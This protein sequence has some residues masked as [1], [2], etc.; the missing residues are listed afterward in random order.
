MLLIKS[1]LLWA[2]RILAHRTAWRATAG[3]NSFPP[4][5]SGAPWAKRG[6]QMGRLIPLLLLSLLLTACADGPFDFSRDGV[7]DPNDSDDG[8]FSDDDDDGVPGGPGAGPMGFFQIGYWDEVPDAG[9]S[10]GG[11]GAGFNAGFIDD[12]TQG[13][14]STGGVNFNRAK[15]PDSCG[16]T[17]W[18]AEDEETEG[19]TPGE[20]QPL[21]AGVLTVTS[22]SWE[23]SVDVDWENGDFHYNLEFDPDWEIHFESYYEVRAT[24]GTFPGFES[25]QELLL[26]DPIH[27]LY[28]DPDAGYDVTDEDFTIEWVGGTAEELHL[29]FHNGG[30]H[31][32]NNVAINCRPLN[33]GSFTIPG[34]MVS[35]FDNQQQIQLLLSQT[36][37]VELVVDDYSIDVVSSVS[38][39][40]AG[41]AW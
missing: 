41:M 38:T 17:V 36:R 4:R 24:G 15:E 26:P 40:A 25:T 19:G 1:M 8:G 22:P 39:T 34:E 14:P 18:N 11:G 33:D 30:G 23:A 29:E 27:L 35:L 9:E 2:A 31:E 10:F 7:G 28:P 37:N 32:F 12:I 21:H 3:S 16:V 13:S 6:V 5:D 20:S